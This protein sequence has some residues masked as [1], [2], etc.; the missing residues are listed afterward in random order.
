MFLKRI[1]MQGFKSFVDRTIIEF[2]HPITGVVG[3][4]GCGKSNISDAIRWVLGEQSAKSLRGDKMTDVIFAGSE[5]RKAVSMAEVS[6]VFDNSNKKLNSESDEI[7]VTRRIYNIEDQEAEYLI[8]RQNVRYKDVIDLILDSGLGKDSL[9]MFSQGNI[10]SFAE[11]K[12]YD[13]RALFEDAAGVAKYKKRKI[14]SLAKLERTKENLDRTF[15][16]LTELERQVTPLK[17]QAKKAEIYREKKKRLQEIEIAVIVDDI[18]SLN[19]QKEENEKSMFDLESSL[20]MHKTTIQVH[21]TNNAESRASLKEFDKTINQ[22][23]DQLVSCLNEIKI[24]ETQ[25]VEI[26]ERRK[27]AI[28]MGSSKE[29]LDE[30]KSM[31]DNAKYEYE[32]RLNRLNSFN[33]EME[34]LNKNIEELSIKLA[35]SSL[36]KEESQNVLNR[37]TNRIEVLENI[38]KDPFASSAHSGIKAIIDSKDAFYGIMG[39]V[40]QEIKPHENYEYA[41]QAALSNSTYHIVVKD[42]E[43]ARK[44]I[45]F[46]KK[47]E[48]GRATFLPITV[49]K[50]HEI[51]YE[52]EVVCKNTKGYLGVAGDFI[53]CEEEYDIVADA[54][55]NNI[56]VVDNLE[57]ANNLAALLKY[58]YKIVTLEGDT[59][60]KGGSISGGKVKNEIS[61]VTAETELE[62]CKE[63]Y[64]SFNAQNEIALKEYG[65]LIAKKNK[66]E[67]EI[68]EKRINIAQLEPLVDVKRAKYESLKANYETI[69]PK[70]G[71]DDVTFEDEIVKKLSEYYS[72]KDELSTSIRVKRDQRIKLSQEIDRRDLQLKQ[73][74]SQSDLDNQAILK[75]SSDKASIDAKLENNLNRL[76]SEY[77]MTYEYAVTNNSVALNG[78]EKEEVQQLRQEISSLGNINMAA[79]E[80]FNEVNERYEFLKKNYDDLIASRD[81]ILNAIDEMDEI[82]KSQF[83]ETFDAINAELNNTFKAL[84]GGGKAKLVLEDENDILNTGIDIDVQPPGKAVKSIRLFS[85]GEK[86]LIAMC[87]LFTILKVNPSPLVIFDEPE[88]ALDQ[89][90]VERFAKY[91]KKFSDNSQFIV[92]THRPGTMEQCDVLY[93]VTMQNRGVSQMIKVK[94]VDAIGMAETEDKTT[95]A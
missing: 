87:V 52:D 83:K 55:L 71:Q 34:L 90:N 11:A 59:V 86:T 36:K 8:N 76:A 80:E 56:I 10:A 88:S 2:D 94:L 73:M 43:A 50:N 35:D 69:A 15:D 25:K 79:P 84:F 48:S 42:E 38:L 61:I 68:T 49:L 22:L 95:E 4:N 44:A 60:H 64:L 65:E 41:I 46:L 89:A 7:E 32:D 82:M 57:N 24:L 75:V 93:G 27:Y 40:G 47:N 91:L 5:S 92:I 6:L 26:D 70:E 18:K 39:V 9:S 17:R 1:E 16:I 66:F 31:V 21:E 12:P 54:L 81:K 19:A 37:L 33:N 62:R 74:R 45:A 77:Q 85:G 78:G 20:A 72:K 3:P 13:R 51:K 14:E 53:N 23:Q 28:E 58:N 30:L 67:S 29:K 63:Q